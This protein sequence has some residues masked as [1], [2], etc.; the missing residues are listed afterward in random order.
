MWHLS[1]DRVE[2]RH[3][4]DIDEVEDTGVIKTKYLKQKLHIQTHM[5]KLSRISTDGYVVLM[6]KV[7]SL[8]LFT[9]KTF[10]FCE[11]GFLTEFLSSQMVVVLYSLLSN[12]LS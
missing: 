1:L 5:M 3:F 8:L 9:E 12:W 7:R 11:V 10:F 4:I 2:C 6:L